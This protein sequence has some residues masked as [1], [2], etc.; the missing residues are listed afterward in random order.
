M[1]FQGES[2]SIVICI[3]RLTA[4]MV[5]Q[6][7]KFKGIIAEFVGEVQT[8]YSVKDKVI[9]GQEQICLISWFIIFP[10]SSIAS[11]VCAFTNVLI[12]RYNLYEQV[13]WPSLLA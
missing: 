8:D 2:G 1:F 7:E 11:L 3:S 6:K 12:E 4:V 5:D 13:I 10:I 9:Q